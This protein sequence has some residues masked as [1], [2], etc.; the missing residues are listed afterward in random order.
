MVITVIGDLIMDKIS[1]IVPVYNG[2]KYLADCIKSIINQSYQNLEIILID[3]GSSD[4]SLAIC[5]GFKNRDSRIRL[6]QKNNAGIGPAR[7][8]GIAISTGKYLMFSDNDDLFAP[9]LVK[10]LHDRIVQD[11]SDVVCSLC[12]R[13]DVNGCY[14]F[15]LDHG[16]PEK[17]VQ[18]GVYSPQQY[19]TMASNSRALI[20]CYDTPW[21]KLYDRKVFKNVEYPAK[22]AEDVSTTWR[23]YLNAN[24]ISYSHRD[25]Y[26][27]RMNTASTTGTSGY[28]VATYVIPSYEE[29]L[30]F[31]PLVGV[32]PK[33]TFSQYEYYLHHVNEV[34]KQVGDE[35]NFKNTTCK[36]N[37]LEKYRHEKMMNQNHGV[38]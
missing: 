19:L 29:R 16:N 20:T 1:I 33:P 34:A 7:N 36:I 30:A 32:D 21:G 9:D 15:Y 13:R 28:K 10:H 35:R 3:D 24:N 2:E 38:S 17:D 8:T 12:Y 37:I 4:N 25:E 18:D 31:I 6:F 5:Q 14:Y 22:L 27:W 11:G 26:C 23:L